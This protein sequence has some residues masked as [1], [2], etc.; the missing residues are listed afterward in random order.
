ML[1]ELK[2]ADVYETFMDR[3]IGEI[4]P[5]NQTLIRFLQNIYRCG[6]LLTTTNYDYS[7]EEALNCQG[8]T[9]KSPAEILGIINSERQ[10]KVIHLHGAYSKQH[11]ID[12]IVASSQQYEGILEDKAAQFMQQLISTNTIIMIGC[13]KTTEDKNINPFLN[14]ISDYLSTDTK[15]FYVC[16]SGDDV[17]GLP[18]NAIPI[19]YGDEYGDLPDFLMSICTYRNR[20]R[21][22]LASL[23]IVNPYLTHQV[24]SAAFARLHFSSEYVDFVGRKDEKNLLNEFLDADEQIKWWSINGEGGIGKS[25]LILDWLK[26]SAGH[27]WYGFFAKVSEID[28]SN[29]ITQRHLMSDYSSFIPFTDTVIVFDYIAGIEQQC[30]RIIEILLHTFSEYSYKLRMIFIERSDERAKWRKEVERSLNNQTRETFIACA[31]LHEA[32]DY[33]RYKSLQLMSF[34]DRDEAEFITKYLEKSIETGQLQISHSEISDIVPVIQMAYRESIEAKYDRPLFLAVF[35]EVWLYKKDDFRFDS[36]LSL[37]STYIERE[38]ERWKSLIDDNET[39][40]A[41]KTL[42]AFACGVDNYTLTD[43]YNEFTIEEAKVLIQYLHKSKLNGRFDLV[44]SNLGIRQ[45]V[46]DLTDDGF[47]ID[48]LVDESGEIVDMETELRVEQFVSIGKS[49]KNKFPYLVL[50]AYYPDVIREMIVLSYVPDYLAEYYAQCCR[51][52][53]PFE[54]GN[55]LRKALEDYPHNDL[56][57]SMLKSQMGDG[58]QKSFYLLYLLPSVPYLKN[59]E[60]L[61]RL[62]LNLPTEEFD[63]PIELELWNQLLIAYKDSIEKCSELIELFQEYYN[64]IKDQHF[65][66]LILSSLLIHFYYYI[67]ESHSLNS[68]IILRDVFASE[69]QKGN[70]LDGLIIN[71]STITCQ[72]IFEYANIRDSKMVKATWDGLIQICENYLIN[73]NIRGNVIRVFCFIIQHVLESNETKQVA[74]YRN[75]FEMYNSKHNNEL[76]QNLLAYILYIIETEFVEFEKEKRISHYPLK[77]LRKSNVRIMD[78]LIA[79][80]SD[81]IVLRSCYT[82]VKANYYSFYTN[83]LTGKKLQYELNRSESWAR[84]AHVNYLILEGFYAFNKLAMNEEFKEFFDQ[85][86][87]VEDNNWAIRRLHIT[88]VKIDEFRQFE[89]NQQSFN[90][91]D[92]FVGND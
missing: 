38:E 27:N 55:F 47:I 14:F 54:F 80:W 23:Q 46:F 11:C 36:M 45:A 58:E 9:Y 61:I 77:S 83:E 8:V 73:Q 17:D 75:F 13:G 71:Y 35:I 56:F 89:P 50:S 18:G 16:L 24:S 87:C 12:D 43:K 37:L 59:P 33:D 82:L 81:S 32:P 3:T 2:K 88:S 66:C 15:Y 26:N 25:R 29:K 79:V 21:A 92:N 5:Q 52:V 34:S 78:D 53:S 20:Y 65:D 51:R 91:F 4:H 1:D 22:N 90:G 85:Q 70:T 48:R 63:I 49:S 72:I 28:G 10:N 76:S 74:Y 41:Y 68:L 19:Y 62:V 42:L 30:G 64:R 31:F 39:L 67:K 44:A 40:T 86:K 60:E 7:I 6:D 84:E 69:L 57:E